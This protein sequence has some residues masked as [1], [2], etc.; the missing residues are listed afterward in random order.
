MYQSQILPPG[1]HFIITLIYMAHFRPQKIFS[2]KKYRGWTKST[3]KRTQFDFELHF[4]RKKKVCKI[5]EVFS[6]SAAWWQNLRLVHDF[7]ECVN[8]EWEI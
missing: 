4:L 1:S 5:F 3:V 7:L 6:N 2:I 8:I